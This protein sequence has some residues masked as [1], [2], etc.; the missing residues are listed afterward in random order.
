MSNAKALGA[1]QRSERLEG[2][3]GSRAGKR[4]GGQVM[5]GLGDPREG[6][7]LRP[8]RS[9]KTHFFL[10]AAAAIQ[11][12]SGSEAAALG[13]EGQPLPLTC[14]GGRASL[15]VAAS[16][17]LGRRQHSGLASSSEPQEACQR[18]PAGVELPGK[19]GRRGGR[20]ENGGARLTLAGVD[21]LRTQLFWP[22]PLF[23]FGRLGLRAGLRR[24]R[25]RGAT[26]WV[27]QAGKAANPVSAGLS[28]CKPREAF[29][30]S[31][32]KQQAPELGLF[33]NLFFSS[34]I[35]V[36]ENAPPLQKRWGL[37]F[38]CLHSLAIHIGD[39]VGADSKGS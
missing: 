12:F 10:L 14:H 22:C 26:C 36:V 2:E 7:D 11:S 8:S 18:G 9:L 17:W 19:A 34:L 6:K 3:R 1:L 37:E 29:K 4:Q 15:P 28:A 39:L 16:Q 38:V 32:R 25:R 31:K 20:E 5:G 35:Q 23:T 27:A 13:S 21:R 30:P 24:Q 33:R